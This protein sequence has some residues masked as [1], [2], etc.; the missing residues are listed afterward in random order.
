MSAS[1]AENNVHSLD[2]LARNLQRLGVSAEDAA[3]A[4]RTFDETLRVV[5]LDKLAQD[6]PPVKPAENRIFQQDDENTSG[7]RMP[8]E[9]IL[10]DESDP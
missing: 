3:L 10:A 4:F 6:K 8:S 5:E 9:N 2:I 1:A 7:L